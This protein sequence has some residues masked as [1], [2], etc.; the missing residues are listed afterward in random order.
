[1]GPGF[2]MDQID[3]LADPYVTMRKEGTGLGLAIVKKIV[4][5]HHAFFSFGNRLE[6]GGC[7]TIRFPLL[8]DN[9]KEILRHAPKVAKEHDV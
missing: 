6:G 2:P 9:E 3:R 8:P 1:M 5:D 7:V 4:E